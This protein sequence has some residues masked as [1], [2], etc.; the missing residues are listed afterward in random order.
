MP[1][2]ILWNSVRLLRASWL[3]LIVGIELAE[4]LQ[5]LSVLAFQK[6]HSTPFSSMQKSTDV[7]D[8]QL[9]QA[10]QVGNL[11]R[12]QHLVALGASINAAQQNGWTA[13]MLA[14]N[15]R[16]F[17]VVKFL[18]NHGADVHR[19]SV[20][21]NDV[22]ALMLAAQAGSAAICH[23]LLNYGVDVNE[24]DVDGDTALMY[25][26]GNTNISPVQAF[27][28]TKYLLSRGA[29]VQVKDKLG[30]TPLSVVQNAARFDP[31]LSAVA[32]LLIANRA[33]R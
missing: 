2:S 33:S 26:V 11:I 12:V 25:V 28:V 3:I 13:L 8:R 22:D 17:A 6:N 31:Q 7:L 30:N 32:K 20:A 10:A 21:Y 23:L 4:G 16:R 24:T 1:S 19:R 14:A 27:Q 29:K 18:L 5:P 15:S 9:C